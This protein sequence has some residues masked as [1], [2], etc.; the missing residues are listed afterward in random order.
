MSI[1]VIMWAL[2]DAPVTDPTQVLLLVALADRAEPDGSEARPTQE[3]LADRTRTST[4]TVRRV[5]KELEAAGVIRR[6]NQLLA[7][8]YP[9]NRRPV[10][11]DLCISLKR[12]RE[13]GAEVV[14]GRYE[15]TEATDTPV[16]PDDVFAGQMAGQNVRPDNRVRPDNVGRADRSD[17]QAGHCCPTDPSLVRP[18]SSPLT[19]HAAGPGSDAEA[20]G[21]KA[22]T[23]D[24]RDKPRQ[25]RSQAYDTT[26]RPDVNALCQHLAERIVANGS[27]TPE[28]TYAWRKEARNLIDLDKV[29]PEEAHRLIDWCQR[30]HFWRSVIVTMGKFREKYDTIR[31]KASSEEAAKRQDEIRAGIRPNPYSWIR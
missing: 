14:E 19:P 2:N 28:I 4:R 25:Q 15:V 1:N 31:L 11:W 27:R 23:I 22:E 3:W 21:E 5:L 18:S 9:A 24:L 17:T 6:G 7:S 20:E 16:R 30:D 12:A 8:H 26:Q 13:V 10:V 29:D